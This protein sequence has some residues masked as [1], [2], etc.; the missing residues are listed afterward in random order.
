M[1][2]DA[3]GCFWKQPEPT[4]QWFGIVIRIATLASSLKTGKGG[5]NPAH[6]PKP[7]PQ[8]AVRA[9][10]AQTDFGRVLEVGEL[11]LNSIYTFPKPVL[12]AYCRGKK[13]SLLNSPKH[14]AISRA[15]WPEI[16]QYLKTTCWRFGSSAHFEI[17][18][19]Q[20]WALWERVN[21]INKMQV[22][23]RFVCSFSYSYIPAVKL[24]YYSNVLVACQGLQ[25]LCRRSFLKA[26]SYFSE[27]IVPFLCCYPHIQLWPRRFTAQQ[28]K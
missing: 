4:T 21:V 15:L 28:G 24:G 3:Q 14:K 20:I 12:T 16:N 19:P 26:C 6:I 23:L 22:T 7:I 9:V 11:C 25:T 18:Y 8:W 13:K 10:M 5:I 1:P 17:A 27:L 2:K